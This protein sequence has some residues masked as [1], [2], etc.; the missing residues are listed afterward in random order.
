M[1]A[2]NLYWISSLTIL[3]ADKHCYLLLTNNRLVSLISYSPS[4]LLSCSKYGRIFCC[5]LVVWSQSE[6]SAGISHW[7]HS[8]CLGRHQNWGMVCTRTS[9][10]MLWRR[11]PS[12]SQLLSSNNYAESNFTKQ[13]RKV[14][15]FDNYK[16]D[17]VIK[18]ESSTWT[19]LDPTQTKLL[20]SG[21]PWSI[22]LCPWPYL[23][24]FGIRERLIRTGQMTTTALCQPWS[25][26][27]GR[28]G[29]VRLVKQTPCSLLAKSK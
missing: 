7:S 25:T 22:P 6:H 29:L 10:W 3:G 28:S 5:L 27:G 21:M 9:L 11:W 4:H 1:F 17:W 8:E 24:P 15:A 18:N 19:V 23:E 26:T 20:F 2:R 16:I 13:L 12:V 14:F